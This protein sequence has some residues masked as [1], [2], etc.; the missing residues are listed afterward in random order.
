MSTWITLGLV[1]GVA[2]AAVPETATRALRRGDC[3]TALTA[4][5][6]ATGAEAA[7]ARAGCGAPDPLT[8]ELADAPGLGPYLRLLHARTILQT[9]P[10]RVEDLLV[11]VDLPGAAG[12]EARLLVGRARIALDRSYDARADLR[13]L[14]GTDVAPE[15]RYWLAWGAESRG[16]LGPA[17]STYEATW[18]RHATSVWAAAAAE[19]LDAL[20]HAVPDYATEEGRAMVLARAKALVEGGRAPDA[21]ELY[22]GLTH[23]TGDTSRA[24]TRQVAFALFKGRQ[25]PRAVTWF[26]RLEPEAGRADVEVLYHYALAWSRTG[27]YDAASRAYRRLVELYPTSR[28]ADTASYKLGYLE[29]DR[30]EVDR[31]RQELQAHLDRYPT[32]R[33]GDEALWYLGWTAYVSRDLA[34]AEV[35]F[36]DLSRTFPKSSLVPGARYWWA[37]LHG[38]Q[39]RAQVERE[40]LEALVEQFPTSGAAFFAAERLGLHIAG[41]GPAEVPDFPTDFVS[42]NP[43]LEHAQTLLRAGQPGFAREVLGGLERQA[44]RWGRDAALALAH[45]AIEAGDGRLAKRLAGPW[46]GSVVAG[47]DPTALQACHPRPLPDVGADAA[48]RSGLHPL[49]PY[50]IM[51][52]E[53]GLRPEVTSSAGARGLMQVMPSLGEELHPLLFEGPFDPSRLYDP[54]YNTLLGTTELGRLHARWSAGPIQPALPL[55]IAGYNGGVEAVDRWQAGY[56]APPSGDRFAEDISYP[57]TRRYVRRVLGYLMTYRWVYGDSDGE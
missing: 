44:P 53:S 40:M 6:G 13:E 42:A 38:A 2:W 26:E 51:T 20:G 52:A 36:R 18:S 56:D 39:G 57:E 25:Y 16:D 17:V 9:D 35:A 22:D 28:R 48:S 46:C 47:K 54:G 12:L 37:R 15:A 30:G 27:D 45:L 3:A 29:V 55:V 11:G 31:A 5:A 19:R 33:H 24:W 21:G 34:G 41:A 4:L 1:T 7:L 23:A 14:L 32:S 10:A 8:P 49:L 43:S 50:A